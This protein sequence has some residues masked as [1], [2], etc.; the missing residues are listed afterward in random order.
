MQKRNNE[1][2][3]ISIIMPV[4]N[5]EKYLDRAIN[6]VVAQTYP[7]WE[8]LLVDDCSADSSLAICEAWAEKDS[9]IRVIEHERNMGAGCSR[10]DGIYA[11]QGDYIGFMD[12]DD[13][14]H[15]QMY[16]TLVAA[17]KAE[18]AG[19]IMCDSMMLPEGTE[20]Q[21]H[22]ITDHETELETLNNELAYARMFGSSET[23][24]QYLVLWNK[25]YRAE[26]AKMIRIT[27]R[28]CEDGEF[29]CTAIRLAN[30]ITKLNTKPLYF[31]VQRSQSVSHALFNKRDLEVLKS[32]FEMADEIVAYDPLCFRSVAVKTYKVVLYTRYNSRKTEFR[33]DVIQYIGKRF[34]D[35]NKRFWNC[36]EISLRWKFLLSIFYYC[37]FTYNLFR[38]FCG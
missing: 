8:L 18:K 33:S 21:I 19:I 1:D 3:L 35:F 16:E 7:C 15:P 9:R 24:W 20:A 25:L 13:I 23:D 4:Y 31:W 27:T 22:P 2:L 38:A 10:T 29:N 12:S 28:G 36:K 6:C 30:G 37:P 34:P 17:A 32:Y 14:I 5:A 26:I 11:A